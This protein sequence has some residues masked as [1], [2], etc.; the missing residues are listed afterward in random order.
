[1]SNLWHT[2]KGECAR[3]I[4]ISKYYQTFNRCFFSQ[5]TTVTE[6]SVTSDTGQCRPGQARSGQAGRAEQQPSLALLCS[7]FLG[8]GQWW[9]GS[10]WLVSLTKVPVGAGSILDNSTPI[11]TDVDQTLSQSLSSGL[12]SKVNYSE[13]RNWKQRK[14][15]ESKKRRVKEK[16]SQRKEKIKIYH[17]PV[18]LKLSSANA[19]ISK[20]AATVTSLNLTLMVDLRLYQL[21]HHFFAELQSCKLNKS[22]TQTE[23]NN[24]KSH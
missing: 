8:T 24:S 21:R 7:L 9:L 13:E 17:S 10:S 3:I 16:K 18:S 20:T 15:E 1:M 14:S 22:Q 19:A 4:K 12:K 11:G 6:L 23:N 5:V 2:K